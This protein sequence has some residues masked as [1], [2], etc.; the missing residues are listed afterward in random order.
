MTTGVS[1]REN[2]VNSTRTSLH[3]G[4]NGYSPSI[5][6][7]SYCAADARALKS[8]LDAHRDGFHSTSSI[9]MVD[10]PQPQSAEAVPTRAN[11][12]SQIK[13]VC[14]NA[15]EHDTL[16]IQFS[17]HGTL[18]ADGRLYLLPLDTVRKAIVETSISW[19]WIIDQVEAS[20]ASKK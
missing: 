5:G 6:T 19:Q 15:I 8:I 20:P 1:L 12:I 2:Y 3:I 16:L 17:G 14:E 7:L 10:Q 18:G 13:E 9:L 11:I 4:V